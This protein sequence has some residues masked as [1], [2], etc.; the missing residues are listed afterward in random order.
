MVTVVLDTGLELRTTPG[1][2]APRLARLG[3]LLRQRGPEVARAEY[4]DLRFD[5]LIIGMRE[6]E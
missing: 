3:A 4:V 6:G 2:L 5:D 1:D